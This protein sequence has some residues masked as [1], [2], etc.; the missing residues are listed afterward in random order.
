MT[1]IKIRSNPYNRTLE[2]YIYKDHL[3]NWEDIQK[4]SINSKLREN[5]PE[6]IFLPFKVKEIVDTLIAEYYTG[7]D[8]IEIVFEG[9]TDEYTELENICSEE[10]VANK[11]SLKR[12]TAVLENARDI[13]DHTKEIFGVVHPMIES[14]VK[15]D[16][17]ITK[18]MN[19]VADAMKDIIPICIFGNYSAG[20]STFINSLI[21]YEILPSGG[22]PVTAKVFEIKRSRHS[23][24]GKISF[25]YHDEPFELQFDEKE[26]RVTEGDKEK[27]IIQSLFSS[28]DKLSNRN[29]I[30]MLNKSIDVINF[31]ERRDKEVM[32][33]GNVIKVEVPFS[34][35]GK[36]GQ[37]RNEFVIF[38]TPGSNSQTNLDHSQVLS[39]SL[40]GFSNG[41]PVWVSQYDSIDSV[42]NASLCD[43]LY[44]IEALDKRFTM[45]VINKADSVELPKTG[46][47]S[48]EIND[49]MEYESVEKM[50]SSGIYFVSS[51]MGLG[52][53]EKDGII[54]DYLADVYDE[55]EKKFGDPTAR[56]YKKLYEYNIMPEQMKRRAMEYSQECDNLIYANSGVY[57]VEMEM[58]QFASRHAAYNKCQ[59]VYS[60]LKSVINETTRRVEDKAGRLEKNKEKMESE[61]DSKK[62]EL[63]STIRQKTD[64]SAA[65][66]EKDANDF[67]SCYVLENLDYSKSADN[68]AE[69][70]NRLAEENSAN[71]DFG[72]Y[73]GKYEEAKNERWKRLKENS[74]NILKGDRHNFVESVKHLATDWANDSKELQEKKKDMDTVRS[75]VDRDTSDT[76]LNK[77][78]DDYRNNI[79]N[80]Q[81]KLSE[82]SKE[83]WQNN[84]SEYRDEMLKIITGTDALS[85]Q[86]RT[87]LSDVILKYEP[88]VFDDNA[89]KVF[90]KAKFLRGNVLGI[91]LGGS[92]R[93]DIRRLVSSYNTAIKKNVGEMGRLINNSCFTSFKSWQQKL[94]VLIEENITIYNPELRELTEFIRDENERI[95]ELLNNQQTIMN[96]FGTIESMMAWKELG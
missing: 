44:K 76:M 72:T 90:I 77:V 88:L 46:L 83:R 84:A 15:D 57:C 52:A 62:Q 58:E 11:V 34:E 65:L 29:L 63:V 10:D 17:V 41:I 59:M 82:V 47:E 20:K 81:D 79:I 55:K 75:D 91:R 1:R 50:Y 9:T 54:S 25:A 19:K 18:G 32:E 27:D 56:S 13:L 28:I 39:E 24:R 94:S 35:N 85:E 66:F 6:K 64:D 43:K 3:E 69:E 73:E 42:D 12:S 89:D 51:V 96:S 22:D 26:C 14:I 80:A 2:Y 48:Y 30:T 31:F 49:I 45:I 53:K 61:L 37:S 74:Q 67:I 93:L 68:L 5:D 7:E 38:D 95:Q 71:A 23:D 21:G 40:E 86:Q 8:K 87:E 78:V 4:E 92:E 36:L 60:F 70:D 33:I 16:P